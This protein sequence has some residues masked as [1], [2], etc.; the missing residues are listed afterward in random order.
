M[1]CQGGLEHPY[2]DI[3]VSQLDRSFLSLLAHA[4]ER[5]RNRRETAGLGLRIG[6]KLLFRLVFSLGRANG[7]SRGKPSAR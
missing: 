1:A 6:E 2:S 4:A 3:D 7:N 5:S